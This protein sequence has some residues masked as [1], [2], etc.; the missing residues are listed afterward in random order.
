MTQLSVIV[1]SYNEEENVSRIYH[2]LSRVLNSIDLKYEII[3]VDDGSTDNTFTKLKELHQKHPDK[4]RIIR[5]QRNFGKAAALSAGW[6]EAKGELIIQMDA[7]LQDDPDE[8]PQFLGKMSTGYDMVS[9]WK[10]KRR[11]TYSKIMASKFFNWLTR[12]ATGVGL[13][14]FNCGFKCYKKKVTENIEIYGELHR[15]I[16]ILAHWRGFRLGEIRVR[17]HPRKY[18]QSKYGFTRLF[19]GFLDLIT[20][21]Y[22]NTYNKRPLHFFALV[23]FFF[24]FLGFLGGIYLIYLKLLGLS[25][26]GRPLIFLTLLLVFL[27]V[28]FISLGLIGEMIT[29]Q[30]KKEEYVIREVLK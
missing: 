11:D 24:A 21:K 16:P 29:S 14:D 26:S 27:G 4:T 8:I 1:P 28:Q 9:G 10:F 23:G 20:V 7:D 2:R 3:F 25:I 30:S 18:G 19:K 6:G 15:Y 22:L 13:H 17:H 12:K 5:L